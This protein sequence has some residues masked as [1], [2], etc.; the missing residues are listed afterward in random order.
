MSRLVLLLTFALGGCVTHYPHLVTPSQ[1][2][3]DSSTPA[4]YQTTGTGDFTSGYLG[5]VT[6]NDGL[7]YNAMTAGWHRDHPKVAAIAFTDLYGNPLWAVSDEALSQWYKSTL[8][9]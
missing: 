9:P 5:K 3:P 6:L 2:A 7:S 4:Q 8:N 1:A